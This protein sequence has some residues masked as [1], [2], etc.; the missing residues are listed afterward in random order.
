MAVESLREKWSKFGE[1]REAYGK[2]QYRAMMLVGCSKEKGKEEGVREARTS[3]STWSER[4]ANLQWLKTSYRSNVIVDRPDLR[5]VNSGVGSRRRLGSDDQVGATSRHNGAY[6]RNE[7][8]GGRRK[9]RF[10]K[11]RQLRISH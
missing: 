7:D 4:Q 6:E 1:G 3:K 5:L 10:L 8:T 2:S 9:I 11:L